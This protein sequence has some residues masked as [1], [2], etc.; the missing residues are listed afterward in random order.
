MTSSEGRR[1]ASHY[2]SL[3]DAAQAEVRA[4]WTDRISARRATLDL[5]TQFEAEGRPYAVLDDDG[6]VV[7]RNLA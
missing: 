6:E 4:E 7:V 5:G 2:D 1:G 3:D